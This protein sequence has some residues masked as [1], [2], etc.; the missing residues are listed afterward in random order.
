METFGHI[1]GILVISIVIGIFSFLI[2]LLVYNNKKIVA[3]FSATIMILTALLFFIPLS[4]SNI[5]GNFISPTYDKINM[6]KEGYT[7]IN[8]K[9]NKTYHKV[10]VREGNCTGNVNFTAYGSKEFLRPGQK[11]HT[12]IN[13]NG[14]KQDNLTCNLLLCGENKCKNIITTKKIIINGK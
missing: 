9:I 7:S 10:F 5:T 14:L 13:Y 12:L 1:I 4:Q 3:E 2:G 11:I 8:F 6:S